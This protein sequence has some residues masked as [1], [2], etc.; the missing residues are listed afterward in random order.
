[1]VKSIDALRGDGQIAASVG[2]QLKVESGKKKGVAGSYNQKY[3]N[4]TLGGN[5]KKNFKKL[6]CLCQDTDG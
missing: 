4:K 3:G 6:G 2:A 1:M 5:R